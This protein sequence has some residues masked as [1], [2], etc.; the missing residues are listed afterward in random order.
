MDRLLFGS[1]QYYVFI[2]PSKKKDG[3][4]IPTFEKMQDEIAK[5]AGYVNTDKNL[6]NEE[7]QCQGELVDLIPR[8]DE[9][10]SMSVQLDKKVMYEVMVVS[11]EARGEYDGKVRVKFFFYFKF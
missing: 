6:S 8:I 7:L 1:S 9:A 4:E 2:D 3:E 5:A 10:N 11:A